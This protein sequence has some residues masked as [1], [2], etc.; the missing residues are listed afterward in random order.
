MIRYNYLQFTHNISSSLYSIT[1]TQGPISVKPKVQ[2]MKKKT[3]STIFKDLFNN[4]FNHSFVLIMLVTAML[5]SHDLA[6]YLSWQE[7]V[8][9]TNIW[10]TGAIMNNIKLM[11]LL[12][13]IHKLFSKVLLPWDIAEFY[14]ACLTC[15][16]F[17][18]FPWLHGCCQRFGEHCLHN[19][20]IKHLQMCECNWIHKQN[21]KALENYF[22]RTPNLT[23]IRW[24][25]LISWFY[26]RK[27]S[28]LWW[29]FSLFG[30][31]SHGEGD[32]E[33]VS[34]FICLSPMAKITKN[35]FVCLFVYS[36]GKD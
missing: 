3:L 35:F 8:V 20:I 24:K 23:T 6:K 19:L 14:S 26:F 21:L 28:W 5:F 31:V 13:C 33:L 10:S 2:E 11:K 17:W 9:A 27:K 16:G 36:H 1:R 7:Y 4:T 15:G 29:L 22:S 30:L 18:T 32:E 34:L 12:A 25:V